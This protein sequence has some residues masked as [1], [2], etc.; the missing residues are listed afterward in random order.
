MWQA[1]YNI[2]ETSVALLP[3]LL[4]GIVVFILF[5][6]AA[7]ILRRLSERFSTFRYGA[8]VARVF[9]RLA[10]VG[11][12]LL[13]FL[14]AVTIVFP[15]M[16]VGTLLSV[17]GLSSLAIGFAVKDIIENLL[18]GILILLRHPFRVGDEITSGTFTG[19]VESI[20]MRA[21]SIKTYDGQRIVIPNSKIYSEP[22]TIITAYDILRSQYD[23]GIGYGDDIARAKQI[24][25]DTVKG[26]DGVLENPG[27]DVL[28]W[29]LAGSAVNLRVRWWT[30]P[31]RPTVVK[32]RDEVL[33]KI[34]KALAEAGIDLP[35]PTQVV[36]FHDQTEETDGDRTAQR[37]G[38]PAGDSPPQPRTIAM[39]LDRLGKQ[40][41]EK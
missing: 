22:V 3:Q 39:G 20:E 35:F 40:G 28:T 31:R 36:L 10:Y 8:E 11:L 23:I 9:G 32:L 37:E 7:K 26:I 29:D 6:I 5:W 19:T 18:A 2:I 27:P 14:V 34:K 38:W 15:S 16:T 13:G 4:V 33:Y 24:A 1:I 17:L 41:Q 30:L 12:I 21:T 25:L